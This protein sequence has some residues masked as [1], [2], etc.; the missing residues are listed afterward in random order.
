[1][2]QTSILS[3]LC[4]LVIQLFRVIIVF[5]TIEHSNMLLQ[6]TIRKTKWCRGKKKKTLLVCCRA[7]FHQSLQRDCY[8]TRNSDAEITWLLLPQWHWVNTH[9]RILKFDRHYTEK[10]KKG[11]KKAVSPSLCPL[12][13]R[14]VSM[15]LPQQHSFSNI[16]CMY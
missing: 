1:M 13:E 2:Y 6:P 14:F 4:C 15:M 11:L 7:E 3:L 8:L 9:L 16:N 5:P 10:G 12:L